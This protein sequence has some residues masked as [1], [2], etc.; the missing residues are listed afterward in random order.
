MNA[1]KKEGIDI[2]KVDREITI[3]NIEYFK[4]EMY[5]LLNKAGDY[6]ILN[7]EDVAY[8]NSSALGII[9]D[10]SLKARKLDKELVVIEVSDALD[11]IFKIVKFDTFMEFF[12]TFEHARSYFESKKMND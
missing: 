9:A 4:E 3:K 10:T 1:Y 8:L 5:R 7:L 6:I 2:L 12:P 11:E